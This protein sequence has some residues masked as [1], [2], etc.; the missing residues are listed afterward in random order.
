MTETERLREQA[1][2]CLRLARA[3]TDKTVIERLTELAAEYL[4]QA[5]ALDEGA[6][7][8]SQMPGPPPQNQPMQQQQQQ[9]QPKPKN[10]DE[11]E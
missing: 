5:Q 3:S 2:R 4:E 9:V 11:K 6:P 1:A 10:D 7:A 8:A